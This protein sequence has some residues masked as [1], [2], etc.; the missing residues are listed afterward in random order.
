MSRKKKAS[1]HDQ[2]NDVLA[3]KMAIGQSK[4][5]D[6]S[7]NETADKIYSWD[8]YHAYK[9]HSLEFANWARNND[10]ITQALGH[11]ARSLEELR[12]FVKEWLEN[13]IL[14]NMSASTVHLKASALAK[15][16]SCSTS[17]FEVD[18]PERR[19]ADIKRSRGEAV[20][21]AHFSEE[22]NA[23]MVTFC[24]CAGLRRSE[25]VQI[26]GEDLTVGKDGNFYLSVTRGTKGG[27][28][29]ITK[30][31]GNPEELARIKEIFQEKGKKK[32]FPSVS[33]AADIHSY[34]SVY[35]CKVYKAA[36]RELKKYKN[37]RLVI[38]KN[39]IVEVYTAAKPG[40]DRSK[41]QYYNSVGQK[42]RHGN[43]AMLPGYR[44]VSSVYACR[45]D[46]KS[47][48]YDR[49]AMFVTS[50][51][52]GHNRESVIAGHYLYNLD[53]V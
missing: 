44:D 50:Q 39:R 16:Y 24:K 18:L 1:L 9:K 22:N 6:K 25:L 8:T 49:Q 20:R 21:D 11:K 31:L 30:L 38:Y 37:E 28:P 26:R 51:A 10:E 33:S 42:D 41:S 13:E 3:K 40:P 45:I 34:R 2:I 53:K 32:V 7:K 5:E 12:P 52:L 14:R 27:R 17:D 35:A 43:I 46:Q 36:E 4:H 47:I 23:D 19:R 48:Y 29:R 15:L